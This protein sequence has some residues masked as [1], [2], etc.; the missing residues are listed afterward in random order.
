MPLI[1]NVALDL[2]HCRWDIIERDQICD[3]SH[4]KVGDSNRSDFTLSIE[5]LHGAL[6]TVIVVKWLVDEI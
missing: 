4:V 1:K 2:I 5:F 3:A 6:G